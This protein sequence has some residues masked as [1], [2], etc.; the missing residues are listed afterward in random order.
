MNTVYINGSFVR[1]EEARISPMDRGFL[2]GE[3]IYEVVPAFGGRLVGLDYHIERLIAGLEAIGLEID[4]A[5]PRWRDLCRTL[6]ARHAGPSVSIYLQVTRGAQAKRAHAFPHEAE[7]TVFAFAFEIPPV[8]GPDRERVR[9][10]RVCTERD[11]RWRR[12]NIKSISLLANVLH[13]Q[14]GVVRGCDE[15]L[16][17][18]AQDQLTEASSSNVFLVRNGVVITPPLSDEILPGVTRR[19]LLEELRREGSLRPEERVVSVHELLSADEVWVTSSS[20]EIVPVVEVDGH[21]V[22]N[23]VP[24]DVWHF[25]QSLYTKNKFR[26]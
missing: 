12:C 1:A 20:K 22:G 9:R 13:F 5:A 23:G 15:T 19:I 25:A 8:P 11:R 6:L 2:F 3:G 16:L 26:Y 17:F 18:N 4:C 10:F 24:G 14:H 7:P 21:R